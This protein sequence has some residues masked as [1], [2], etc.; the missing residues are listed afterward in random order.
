MI[1]ITEVLFYDTNLIDIQ[2]EGI[3]P[4]YGKA[5][6]SLVKMVM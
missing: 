3:Q 4:V 1:K 2:S 5:V 6:L